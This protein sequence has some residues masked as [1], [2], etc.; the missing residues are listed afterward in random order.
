[1]TVRIYLRRSKNDRDKQQFSLDV[2]RD[3][4][5]RFAER[6]FPG[7]PRVYYVDDGKAGDD[8][9]HRSGLKR[10]T[11]QAVTGDVILARDQSRLGRDALE[12]SLVIRELVQ[13]RNCRL[14]YYVNGHEVQFSNAI[15][16]ATTYIQGTGH[17]L[18]LEAIRS[19]TTEALRAKVRAGRIAGGRC[20]GYTL[21]RKTDDAFRQYTVAVVDEQQ[22]PIV[23]RIFDEYLEGRGLKSIAIR[24]N[25]EGVPSPTVG[26]RGS[27]SWAPSGIRAMLRNPRYR[28]LYIH[29]RV[30]KV[31]RRGKLVRIEADPSE[32]L[33]IEMPEWRIVSDDTWLAVQKRFNDN[34]R[35][36]PV[37][38]H[39]KAGG[40]A[41]KYALSGLARCGECGGAIS[42]ANTKRGQQIVRA[43]TC[44]RHRRGGNAVC[45]VSIRRPVEIV[46]RKFAD[47]LQSAVLSPEVLPDVMEGV[48]EELERQV[49]DGDT[50]D[51]L[52]ERLEQAKAAVQRLVRLGSLA[53]DDALGQ[54]ASELKDK[55][56]LVKRLEN[57]ILVASDRPEDVDDAMAEVEEIIRV[58]LA[59]FRER[60][61]ANPH[62]ARDVYLALFPEGLTFTPAPGNAKPR[63]LWTIEGIAQLPGFTLSGDPNE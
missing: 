33:T 28:G 16:Q 55:T 57:Q 15:E 6:E 44:D 45:S 38:R 3:G 48:R 49:A 23:R 20:Y 53:G 10:L 13:D 9:L 47:F 59:G 50:V 1:M 56:A 8:F 35:R 19:R 27:G 24:L 4:A 2:Q 54:I 18:E 11:A 41:S 58:R 61:A 21:T 22:A 43:Y 46:D 32:V 40:P 51:E 36:A 62:G 29:G 52:R 34:K 7:E 30:K 17:Q 37:R 26:R 25:N 63:K 12:V 14:F 39:T 31:R 60:L 42:V 5:D